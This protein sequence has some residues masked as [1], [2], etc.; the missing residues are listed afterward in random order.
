MCKRVLVTAGLCLC[1]SILGWARQTEAATEKVTICH[2]ADS[3]KYFEITVGVPSV[4]AHLAH[5]DCVVDDG[6][7]CTVDSCDADLGCVHAPD[8]GACDD[9]DACTTD[10]CDP[11]TGCVNIPISCDDGDACTSDSCDPASGCQYADNIVCGDGVVCPPEECESDTDCPTDSTCDGCTCIQNPDPQ[12]AGATCETFET[13]NPGSGCTD[14]VCGTILGGGG[15]CVEGATPCDSLAPC[16]T[17]DDCPGSFCSPDS[18]CGTPV[19]APPACPELGTAAAPTA[20]P[21]T[22][23]TFGG[24]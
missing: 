2:K 7:A 24:Q 16:T 11:A 5:G 6:V 15:L 19:C 8:N 12:C 13:C 3:V 4:P 21:G 18:C 1:A 23:P 14:P 9:S 10:S 22:G 17:N 20:N